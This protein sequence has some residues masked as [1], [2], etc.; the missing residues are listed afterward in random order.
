MGSTDQVQVDTDSVA[1]AVLVTPQGDVDMSRS[2]ALRQALRVAQSKRP[3]RLIVNLTGV[4]Y[5]DSSGLA[6]LVEAKRSA[7]AGETEVVLCGMT[8]KVRAIFEIAKLDRFFTIVDT[9]ENAT[10]G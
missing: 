7:K 6:T 8:D 1:G 9:L 4:S 3:D 10:A 5:M 2:P